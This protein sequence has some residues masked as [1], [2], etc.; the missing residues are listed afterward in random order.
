MKVLGSPGPP[1]PEVDLKISDENELLI[2][3]P[4]VFP[5]YYNN[6]EATTTGRAA[7]GYWRTGDIAEI[8][9]GNVFL[10]GRL[11]EQIRRFGYTV[12]PRDVEWALRQN[13]AIK[14]I[15][16]LGRQIV[17]QPNDE[18]LYFIVGD[19]EESELRDYCKANLLFAWR[20]DKI[21]NIQK[22]PRTRNGKVNLVQMKKMAEQAK[23]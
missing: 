12:S 11:Q 6:P 13:S 23:L 19:I 7:G 9:K 1:F 2:K 16:V 10:K 4:G 20:P 21:F 14:D 22:L 8:K 5:G 3:S 17:G 18:L 15:F